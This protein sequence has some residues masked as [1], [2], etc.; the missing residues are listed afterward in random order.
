MIATRLDHIGGGIGN[1]G[2]KNRRALLEVS[3]ADLAL[4]RGPGAR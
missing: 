2:L 3:V 4:R 1:P